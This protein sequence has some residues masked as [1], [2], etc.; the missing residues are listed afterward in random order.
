M[1]KPRSSK[2]PAQLRRALLHAAET[3]V[4]AGVSQTTRTCSTPGCGCHTDPSRRHGPHTYL[5]FR[6]AA[7]KSR[8]LYVA[9]DHVAEALDAKAAWDRFWEA[10]VA[11]AAGNRES[12]RRRWQGDRRARATR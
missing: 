1:V 6:D 4:Q 7:G 11:L 12:L 3:M 9:P 10:A 5:T 2:K 8:S